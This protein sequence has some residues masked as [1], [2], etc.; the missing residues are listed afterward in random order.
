MLCEIPFRKENEKPEV[1]R[2]HV[3][4][5]DNKNQRAAGRRE[6]ECLTSR[7]GSPSKSSNSSPDLEDTSS[8]STEK[9]SSD[10]SPSS[11]QLNANGPVMNSNFG[12]P[13]AQ[14]NQ[15]S[16]SSLSIQQ[17]P[18]SHQKLRRWRSESIL[19]HA[20]CGTPLHMISENAAGPTAMAGFVNNYCHFLQQDLVL[21]SASRNDTTNVDLNTAQGHSPSD[22]VSSAPNINASRCY[23][24]KTNKPQYRRKLHWFCP[25]IVRS[26]MRNKQ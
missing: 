23:L 16:A 26:P 25:S 6:E 3:I 1:Q 2:S 15:L 20:G 11:S 18:I 13:S 10:D 8:S 4:I 7:H 14:P 21:I 5:Y 24:T 19:F 22:S 17:Q 12:R 9:P